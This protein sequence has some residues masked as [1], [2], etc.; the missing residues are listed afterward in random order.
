MYIDINWDRSWFTNHRISASYWESVSNMKQFLDTIALNYG[1][2]GPSD[3]KRVSTALIKNQGGKVC[4][5]SR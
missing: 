3:W 2:E 5:L 4:T 1:L